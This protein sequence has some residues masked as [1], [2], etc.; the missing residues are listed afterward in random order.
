MSHKPKFR[1]NIRWAMLFSLLLATLLGWAVEHHK[2]QAAP[3]TAPGPDAAPA[4][5]YDPALLQELADKLRTLD[6]NQPRCL[7]EGSID[8]TDGQDTASSARD[9]AYIFCRNG[10]DFYGRLGDAETIHH[11]TQNI[12]IRHDLKRVVLSAQ[13]ITLRPPMVAAGALL[14]YLRNESYSLRASV[15]GRSRT[16]SL[17]NEHHLACKEISLTYDTLSGKPQ[18]VLTRTPD[19]SDPANPEKDRVTTLRILHSAASG[20][21]GR[22]TAPADVVQKE[23]GK[24]K[25]T[26]KYAG[27][28][29][30]ML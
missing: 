1:R 16:L 25:L 7:I 21:P 14:A 9:L 24:W 30:I 23:N 8:L 6:L 17:V 12:Y 3:K 18:R 22:Y 4:V 15:S 27:Y 2:R 26:G 13:A 28:K 29:L 19:L 11:G 5:A 10:K 20:K